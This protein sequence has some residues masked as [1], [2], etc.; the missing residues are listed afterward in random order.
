MRAFG[1]LKIM[2]PTFP[3]SW[4]PI[5]GHDT[6][7]I[8]NAVSL[9]RS[10]FGCVVGTFTTVTRKSEGICGQQP[11]PNSIVDCQPQLDAHGPLAT[12]RSTEFPNRVANHPH[13]R[14]VTPD[15]TVDNGVNAVDHHFNQFK[16]I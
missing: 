12:E 4:T 10:L 7:Q 1:V 13:V 8:L 11:S 14:L 2:G 16:S 5:T 6:L 9:G 3:A 15:H